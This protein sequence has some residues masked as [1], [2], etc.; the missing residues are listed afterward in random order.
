[1]NTLPGERG[2]LRS[3]LST[4]AITDLKD[5]L[6]QTGEYEKPVTTFNR[7]GKKIKVT[8]PLTN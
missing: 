1:M 7:K 4:M 8:I 2:I 6:H 3:T 5:R